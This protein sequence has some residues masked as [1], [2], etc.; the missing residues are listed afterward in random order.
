MLI[1]RYL[2]IFVGHNWLGRQWPW[3]FLDIWWWCSAIIF[4]E[5]W[6]ES[7]CTCTS[8]D[9]FMYFYSHYPKNMELF[10][11]CFLSLCC[12]SHFGIF[13][14]GW[15]FMVLTWNISPEKQTWQS[16]ENSRYRVCVFYTF[17]VLLSGCWGWLQVFW[18]TK[19]MSSI[20][21]MKALWIELSYYF[22]V[23]QKHLSPYHPR[24]LYQS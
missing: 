12:F 17:L 3:S 4:K 20:W 15:Q 2:L 7:Y 21:T 11:F 16:E 1:Y 22:S 24:H 9:I 5:T 13:F 8:G 19:G 10:R 18:K 14:S 6:P 23:E